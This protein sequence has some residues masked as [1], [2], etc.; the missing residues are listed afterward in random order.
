MNMR[1]ATLFAVNL[2]L[3]T[4]TSSLA[5]AQSNVG[6]L[7]APISTGPTGAAKLQPKALAC[8]ILP[9]KVADLG[10]PVIGVVD[11]ID[12]DRGDVVKQGQIVAR[13]ASDVEQANAG[14]V[15]S[16]AEA[17]GDLRAAIANDALAQQ[18][19]ERGKKL[20]LK[21]YISDQDLDKIK[22]DAVS[23]EQKVT[24]AREQLRTAAREL[25]QAQAQLAQ[26]VVRSPID[27]VIVERYANPGERVE[28]KP[29]LKVASVDPL[30]VEVVAPIEMFGKLKLQQNATVYANLAGAPPKI[31]QITQID[32]IVDP[33]SNTFRLRLSLANKDGSL[34]AGLRCKIDLLTPVQMPAAEGPLLPEPGI[35]KAPGRLENNSLAA[36]AQ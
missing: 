27:G 11:S 26:R 6:P 28:E 13:L 4:I 36:A 10:S 23:A 22:S 33:A 25:S 20:L 24:E 9:D 18:Q 32:H 17:E 1:I 3:L 7:S 35:G 19:V 34:P 5:Q 21:G 16:R 30:R 29:L 2:V 15:R 31:A 8:L 14:V 12:V